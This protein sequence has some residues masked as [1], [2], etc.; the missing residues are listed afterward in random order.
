MKLFLSL[1]RLEVAIGKPPENRCGKCVLYKDLWQSLLR[2]INTAGNDLSCKAI[3]DLCVW[4]PITTAFNI[5]K[6][7]NDLHTFWFATYKVEIDE[8][9]LTRNSKPLLYWWNLFT[10][11]L[12]LRGYN[13]FNASGIIGTYTQSSLCFYHNTQRKDMHIMSYLLY[14]ISPKKLR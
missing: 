8:D 10:N 4:R 9:L 14:C 3:N 5:Q 12:H 6:H 7:S 1:W 13:F 2:L 11:G